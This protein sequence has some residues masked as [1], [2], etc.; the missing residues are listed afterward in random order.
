M[1]EKNKKNSYDYKLYS[2]LIQRI[3]MRKKKSEKIREEYI[4]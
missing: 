3:K 4:Q 1:F 2:I